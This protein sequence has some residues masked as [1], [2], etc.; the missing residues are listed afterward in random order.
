MSSCEGNGYCFSQTDENTYEQS[1]CTYKCEL[2]ECKNYKHCGEK[3]PK[4][5]L[6]IHN[7]MCVNCAAAEYDDTVIFTDIK[8]DCPVCYE[9]K[10]MI[11][12][13][14]KHT[15]CLMCLYGMFAHNENTKGFTPISERTRCPL[16]RDTIHK[17]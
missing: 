3:R 16:C 15:I 13:P 7:N 6:D 4:W 17:A 10:Y 12:L 1:V 9:E 8:Q 11:Q 2:L 5:V 14:C